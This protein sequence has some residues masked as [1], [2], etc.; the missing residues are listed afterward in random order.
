MLSQQ[1]KLNLQLLAVMDIS[2]F[3]PTT[4]PTANPNKYEGDGLEENL[5][6]KCCMSSF[7]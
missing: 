6:N 3:N 2:S 5:E 4:H 7:S 1:S